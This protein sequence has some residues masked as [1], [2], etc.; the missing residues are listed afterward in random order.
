MTI[1]LIGCYL[2]GFV[3][4]VSFRPPNCN[5]GPYALGD[6]LKLFVFDRL[7]GLGVAW[8]DHLGLL[9]FNK[10]LGSLSIFKVLVYV[11]TVLDLGC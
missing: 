9:L 8:K 7:R 3:R 4:V 2:T 1:G 5:V 11:S 10:C 6:L